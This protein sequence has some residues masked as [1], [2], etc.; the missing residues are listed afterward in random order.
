MEFQE[1]MEQ[2][3]AGVAEEEVTPHLRKQQQQGIPGIV[4]MTAIATLMWATPKK[5]NNFGKA[6]RK[7]YHRNN[8]RS[9]K[10]R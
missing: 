6:A 8:Q 5:E 2:E 4:Q 9:Q 3:L 10:Q 1:W 7:V